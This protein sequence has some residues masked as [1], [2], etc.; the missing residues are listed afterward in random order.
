[1]SRSGNHH[2]NGILSLMSP[3]DTIADKILIPVLVGLFVEVIAL[4]LPKSLIYKKKILIALPLIVA[5]VALAF[6]VS[7]L[8]NEKLIIA[9]AVVDDS[10]GKSV[11]GA[12]ISILSRPE[13]AV[14]ESNGN[15]R[16]RF[17]GKVDPEIVMIHVVKSG[18]EDVNVSARPPVHNLVIQMRSVMKY[19]P[20]N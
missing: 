17:D 10:T 11:Q 16:I 4:F 8:N 7:P 15:F 13:T 14:S 12:E 1:M 19:A 2:D 9:G 20:L 3:L 6:Y 5:A 18:Y